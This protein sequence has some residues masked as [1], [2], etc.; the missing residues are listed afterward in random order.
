MSDTTTKPKLERRD[1]SRNLKGTQGEPEGQQP[2]V[3]P[4]VEPP[5]T[6]PPQSKPSLQRQGGKRNLREGMEKPKGDDKPE[7]AKLDE[8]QTKFI[9]DLAKSAGIKLKEAQKRVK[10]QEL[11]TSVSSELEGKTQQIKNGNT[12][13]L[14]EKHS[15]VVGSMLSFVGQKKTL[16]TFDKDADPNKEFEVGNAV[17]G[18]FDELPPDVLRA[19]MQAQ[20]EIVN[21]SDKLR[22]TM[23]DGGTLTLDKDGN[24]RPDGSEVPEPMFSKD[25]I[26]DV[27]YAEIWHPLVRNRTIPENAVP[28]RYSETAK[29]FKGASDEYQK[30]LK[31]YS[32]GANENDDA[33][34]RTALA[35]TVFDGMNTMSGAVIDILKDQFPGGDA[36]QMVKEVAAIQMLIADVSVVAFSV[37]NQI[38]KKEFD[39]AILTAALSA[40]SDGIALDSDTSADH[41]AEVAT[42]KLGISLALQSS[43]VAGYLAKGDIDNAVKTMG[44]VISTTVAS[45]DSGDGVMKNAGADISTAISSAVNAKNLVKA[46]KEGKYEDAMKTFG[47]IVAEETK[48]YMNQKISTE[49]TEK[50]STDS[51]ATGNEKTDEAIELAN[52]IAK[53]QGYFSDMLAAVTSSPQVLLA[54][55][56]TDPKVKALMEAQTKAQDLTTAQK[57]WDKL[58]PMQKARIMKM[59]RAATEVQGDE[60]NKELKD[61][62]DDFAKLTKS[63]DPSDID[64]LIAQVK[65]QQ[66]R[67]TLA[68]T[69]AKL[70]F[71]VIGSMFPPAKMGQS[72]LELANEMRLAI[73][74]GQ[75]YLSWADN[76]EDARR[77]GSVQAEAMTSRMDLS[78][79]QQVRHGIE[80][81]LKVVQIIGQGL[82]IAGGPVAHIGLA[83]D[84]SAQG[85]MA[86]KKVVTAVVDEKRAANAWRIYQKAFED[87]EN[88]TAARKALREN[89]TLAKYAIGYGAK[90]GNPIAKNALRKCGIT[91]DMMADENSGVDKLVSYLETRFNE[92]PI[93]LRRIPIGAWHPGGIELTAASWMAFVGAAETKASPKIK[94]FATSTMVTAAMTSL[95]KDKKAYTAAK[96]DV[97]IA[98]ADAFATRLV[99]MAKVLKGVKVTDTSNKPHKEFADYVDG[100]EALVEYDLQSTLEM[101]DILGNAK[102]HY[103]KLMESVEPLSEE[104]LTLT[105]GSK[106]DLYAR[107]KGYEGEVKILEG[108]VTQEDWTQAVVQA[109]AL[110]RMANDIL[111]TNANMEKSVADLRLTYGELFD[112]IRTTEPPKEKSIAISLKESFGILREEELKAEREQDWPQAFDRIEGMKAKADQFVL[113]MAAE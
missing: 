59:Q 4:S 14:M 95:E 30:R 77:A 8:Q 84:K 92:D 39:P 51:N 107:C 90:A 71:A 87:P 57:A 1:G 13:N 61:A 105:P 97:T 32:E 47:A 10:Q 50:A 28:S 33:L 26:D 7:T 24:K 104:V 2:Q 43:A 70:P 79:T 42:V 110:K 81:A 78:M 76:V 18:R 102:A 55:T 73:D 85:T 88:R 103:K 9:T 11:L 49:M 63:D 72:V 75:Q 112:H 52:A 46:A 38:L 86:A 58:E 54:L 60:A 37:T 35:Q 36:V 80:A 23:E 5:Q 41:K 106:T 68:I 100:L 109:K 111:D 44:A 83:L 96:D 113:E 15:G 101:K 93:I 66:L 64:R 74:A 12:F 82:T 31:K 91:D 62:H 98:L 94:P 56:S 29:T 19:V 48:N 69:L 17:M 53:Q 45:G 40:I 3:E 16:A 25:E 89:A 27:I 99:A 108:H 21:M 65:L 67:Y 22:N 20:A 6:K 34:R